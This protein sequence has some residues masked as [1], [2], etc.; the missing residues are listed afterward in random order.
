MYHISDVQQFMEASCTKNETQSMQLL[1]VMN[2]CIEQHEGQ[3]LNMLLLELFGG[4][5][6]I[7]TKSCA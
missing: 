4:D 3:V 6:D 5:F 2:G 7:S 1:Q